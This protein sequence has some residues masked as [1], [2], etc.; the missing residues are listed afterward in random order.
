M[1]QCVT[2]FYVSTNLPQ[3]NADVLQ[4]VKSVDVRII[5]VLCTNTEEICM[6][7]DGWQNFS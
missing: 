2:K 7:F 4:A 6:S 5:F 1:S 3:L